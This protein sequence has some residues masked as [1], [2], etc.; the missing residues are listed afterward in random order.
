MLSVVDLIAY[1]VSSTVGVRGI[2]Y[3]RC[4]GFLSPSR[5]VINVSFC[6]SQAGIFV[7]TGSATVIAGPAVVL[8]YLFAG[9]A[10]FFSAL[11]YGEFAARIPSACL[12]WIFLALRLMWFEVH[13]TD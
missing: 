13:L 2:I 7:A 8:S 1:G 12:W 10:S 11:C 3:F 6:S 9:L 5:P 4:P